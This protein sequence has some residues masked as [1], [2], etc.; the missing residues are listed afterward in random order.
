MAFAGSKTLAERIADHLSAQII[1]GQLAPETRLLE[2]KLA[3]EL[4]VSKSPLRE[5]FRMLEKSRL[6]EVLPRRGA[7]VTEISPSSITWLFDLLT[8]LHVLMAR[9]TAEIGSKEDHQ[10]LRRVYQ[11]MDRDARA[12]NG[13][14]YYQGIFEFASLLRRAVQ[15][16]MLD[17]VVNDFEPSL[18]RTIY[19][20]VARRRENLREDV[21]FVKKIVQG[22]EARDVDKADKAVRAYGQHEKDLALAVFDQGGL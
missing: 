4:N 8:E 18:R 22:I 20:T 1:T 16:P 5:A 10:E 14:A 7:R 15:N 9:K 19:A 21:R 11:Q 12:G 13:E 6:I 2:T 3:T 17:D